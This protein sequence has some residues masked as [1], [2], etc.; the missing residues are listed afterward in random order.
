MIQIPGTAYIGLV[1][2]HNIN[3]GQAVPLFTP[4][5]RP[6]SINAKGGWNTLADRVNRRSFLKANGREP[7]NDTELYCWVRACL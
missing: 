1:T 4:A 5:D 3:G 6:N 2:H 7:V